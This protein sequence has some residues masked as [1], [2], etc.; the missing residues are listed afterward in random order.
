MY[1]PRTRKISYTT[2]IQWSNSGNLKL[3]QYYHLIYNPYSNF[4]Y[5]PNIAFSR[6]FPRNPESNSGL[7]ATLGHI[8]LVC[9]LK[10]FLCLSFSCMTLTFLKNTGL[11]LCSMPFNLG[12]PGCFFMIKF[13]VCAFG[14]TW[15]R[16]NPRRQWRAEAPAY[17]SPWG[18]KESDTI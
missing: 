17:C 15:I 11:L 9:N 16:A 8:S 6:N 5:Y 12:L 3:R 1:L 2:R 14:W 10:H 13:R 7:S 4:T 18:R